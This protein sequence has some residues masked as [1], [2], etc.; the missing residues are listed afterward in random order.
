MLGYDRLGP[1]RAA[2]AAMSLSKRARDQQWE[3]EGVLG[4]DF[5]GHDVRFFFF[6]FED[7]Y[8]NNNG[9]VEWRPKLMT[10]TVAWTTSDS[11][12]ASESLTWQTSA[13]VAFA[14]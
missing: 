8:K 13:I 10:K 12:T 11:T 14:L 5:D 4:D 6:F 7:K 1:A 9:T 3:E 2:K